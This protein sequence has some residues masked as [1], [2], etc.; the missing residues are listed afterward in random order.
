MLLPG[1]YQPY[2]FRVP[3]RPYSFRVPPPHAWPAIQLRR[4]AQAMKENAEKN[5]EKVCTF[6]QSSVLLPFF[7][8][9]NP[10]H[11]ENK[12]GHGSFQVSSG[13]SIAI[14]TKDSFYK[15]IVSSKVKARLDGTLGRFRLATAGSNCR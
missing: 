12:F 11:I 2:S 8:P 5:Y 10:T 6:T 7:L 3:R 15:L 14:A 4:A 13:K 9:V 1:H